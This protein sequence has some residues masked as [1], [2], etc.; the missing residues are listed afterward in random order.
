MCATKGNARRERGASLVEFAIVLPLLLLVIG[1]LIDFGRLYFT[2]VM[3][4]NAAR[5][6]ARAEM[7]ANN[8]TERANTALSG[9]VQNA[10]V[11]VV[12]GCT[13]GNPTGDA[14]VIVTVPFKWTLL[15]PAAALLGGSIADPTLTGK[16]TMQCGG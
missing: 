12:T 14:Q 11:Q 5:E 10:S 3:I 13:A 2:E 16:A 8:P 9:K 1:G 6:G 15:K 4:T 7:Y